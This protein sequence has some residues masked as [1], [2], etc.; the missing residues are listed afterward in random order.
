MRFDTKEKNGRTVACVYSETPVICDVQSALDLLETEST[1]LC[2]NKEAFCEE[3]FVLSSGIAGEILQKFVTYQTNLAIYGDYSR[4]TSKPLQDFIRE[5]NEGKQIFFPRS[6]DE[7]L[8]R[9]AA[10]E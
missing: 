1:G 3:F 8:E 2:I 5:S 7:A 6:E 4:Y 9:L 10:A